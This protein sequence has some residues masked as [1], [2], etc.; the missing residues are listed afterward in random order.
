VDT[1]LKFVLVLAAA[2]APGLAADG[3]L[4]MTRISVTARDAVFLVDGQTFTGG[5]VF[6]WPAGSK[7][8][9]EIAPW[10][11]AGGRQKTRYVFQRW[12]AATGALGSPSNYATITAD[13]GIAWYN[14]D[15]TT[16]HALTLNFFQCAQAPCASP[17]TIWVNQMAYTQN[18][19]VWIETG[20]T[21][22]LDAVPNPGFVFA[23]WA[24]APSL[25]SVCAFA[26]NDAL[27][28]Y[29]R[30]AVARAIR[31]ATS[32]EGLVV[33]ADRAPVPTPLT[34]EWGWNT[35]HTLG[36]VSPQQ[37]RQG[38]WWV[39]RSWSDGGAL[40]HNYDVAPEPAV[41]SV[42][43]S[44]VPAVAVAV[45]TS[46]AGLVVNVDGQDAVSPY[47]VAWGPGETHTISAPARQTDFAGAPW[48]FRA[49]S[50]AETNPLAITVHESQVDM[51]IRF[52]A[53]YD[54]LSRTRVETVPDGLT[55]TV[56]G[57]ECRAP[58]EFERPV[59]AT[60]RLGGPATVPVAD[61]VRLDLAGWEGVEGSTFQT[62]GGF[63]KVTARYRT[64]YRLSLGTRPAGA[65]WW[66]LTPASPD[67]YFPAGTALRIEIEPADNMQFRHW[68]LDLTGSV[69]PAA[70]VMDAPRAV[71]AILERTPAVAT[72]LRVT[73]AASD[74][75]LE[76]VA[77]GSIAS[78]FGSDWAEATAEG[79]TDP[80][81]QS[82]AGVTLVC[83]GRLLP[84]LY[85]SPEQINF[86]VPSD[87][88]PAA[89]K[90]QVHREHAPMVEVE[91]AV[92][93]HAPGLFVVTHENGSPVSAEAPARRGELVTVYGTG[94]R[95]LVPPS[96]DGFRIP[97][98]PLF[99]L[100]DIAEV[101]IHGR[102]MPFDF[103]GALPGSVGVVVIRLRIPDDFAV[104]SPETVAVRAGG[105]TSNALPLSVK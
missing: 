44:F 13:A 71:E 9:L 92:A 8:A 25:P 28:V 73:N 10:Q 40:H 39:F 77:P 23:G 32:P 104:A 86:Q 99:L 101:V 67:G 69:N 70:L 31:L 64:A 63:R 94:F 57:V 2:S 36:A 17:G 79:L 12:T 37:D 4:V 78:L 75:L 74:A 82:L 102:S 20:S 72:P 97:A 33:L 30:F 84:L 46:P 35:S 55:V 65:G 15:L 76:A 5:A 83:G 11:F 60:V 16:E 43:A 89:Y 87:L 85:V 3:T 14:A 1:R 103:A 62:A 91:L 105:A 95:P 68:E 93:R 98:A 59:G 38:R 48:V 45:D 81:P 100:A 47:F 50:N 22:A 7:H 24:Q 41:A 66:R 58:C 26:L 29:P 6:T 61:G 56:D 18:A 27:T 19:D 42:T 21:V 88:E 53:V 90:L 96:L 52:R 34:L 49:W 80:L 54:P 51:G